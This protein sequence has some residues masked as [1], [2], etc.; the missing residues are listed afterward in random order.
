MA[1]LSRDLCSTSTF[2]VSLECANPVKDGMEVVMLERYFAFV[3]HR[4]LDQS[5][6]TS[7]GWPSIGTQHFW[8]FHCRAWGS[9]S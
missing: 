9:A 1:P 7:R 6:E 8:C 5:R 3:R 4:S 2:A